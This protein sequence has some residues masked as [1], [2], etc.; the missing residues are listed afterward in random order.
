MLSSFRNIYSF[1]IKA[2]ITAFGMVFIS[3]CCLIVY[4]FF[5][6]IEWYIP[7]VIFGFIISIVVGSYIHVVLSI[8]F[9]LPQKFDPIKNKVALRKYSDMQEFQEE[10]ANF[11]LSFFNF[12]GADVIGGKFHFVQCN[13]IV[14]GVEI[15]YSKLTAESFKKNKIRISTHSKAFHLPIILGEEKLGYMILI[16]KG[17]TLPIFYSLLEDFENYYLDDQIKHFVK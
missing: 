15:D 12:L 7:F 6:K 5:D 8:P 10:I 2:A 4:L 13:S 1:I 16:T 17:Y 3:L 14:K 11:I 9:Q